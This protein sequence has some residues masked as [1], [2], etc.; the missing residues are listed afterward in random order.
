MFK[1]LLRTIPTMSGNFKINCS[2]TD[3][4]RIDKE[5]FESYIRVADISPLQNIL[6]NRNIKISLINGSYEYDVCK[7]FKYYSNKFYSDNYS[8]DKSDY[9]TLDLFLDNRL[10]SRNKDYEFGCKRLPFSQTGYQM[11]FYAPIWCDNIN[12]LPDYFTINLKVGNIEK[13][14]KIYIGKYHIKNYLKV[15]LEKYINKI[16]NKV[17]TLNNGSKSAVYY[18]ID[19]N[20]GGIN[21]FN[22]FSIS[23]REHLISQLFD[24]EFSENDYVTDGISL[25]I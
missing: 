17:I 6:L 21:A 8:F 13:N 25:R 24:P 5:N 12:D 3:N 19:V 2:L 18:G 20:K 7:Y 11:N 22:D 10:E 1:S 16:D 15:Y 23:F 9:Q 14:I 4:K